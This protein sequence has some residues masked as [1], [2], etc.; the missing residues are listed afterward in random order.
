[1]IDREQWSKAFY[2]PRNLEDIFPTIPWREPLHVAR[3][4]GGAAGYACRFCIA[5]HGIKGTD[6][7]SL[8]TDPQVVREHIEREHPR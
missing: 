3:L 7:A 6:I 1:M 8:P 5:Q 2:E 4:D